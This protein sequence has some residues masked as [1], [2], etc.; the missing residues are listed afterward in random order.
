MACNTPDYRFQEQP[1][2][3]T[4]TTAFNEIQTAELTPN[5]QIQFAYGINANQIITRSN[6]SGTVSV[7]NGLSAIQT[8]AA[9]NSSCELLSRQVSKYRTGQGGLWRCAGFFTTG[10]AG[11][12]QLIGI[13]TDEDGFFFGYNG[14]DFGILSRRAGVVEIRTLTVATK[15][16]HG[17]NITI[18]L[19]GNAKTDVT[20]TNGADTTVTANEIAAAN[21]SSVGRGW[22][23][24]ANGSKVVFVSWG[25]GARSGTYSL[26]GATS[27]I[28]TFAQTRAGANSTDTWVAQ[29]D[30]NVDTFDGTGSSGVTLN[31]AKGNVYQIQYQWLGFGMIS[32][33]I[34]NP[35]TGK[36]VNVHN[37]QYANANT[38]L[39]VV[40]PTFPCYVAAINTTNTSNITVSTGSMMAGVQGIKEATGLNYGAS[41]TK[42]NAGATEIPILTIRNKV[43]FQNKLNRVTAKLTYMSASVEHTKA[44]TVNFY[45]NATLVGSSFAD[46]GTTT[47]VME[48]DTSA[49]S[50]SGGRKLFTLALGK[51]G[52]EVIQLLDTLAGLLNPGD[53]LTATSIPASQNN[54]ET[55]VS[56]NWTEDF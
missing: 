46:I 37:I 32:F 20:V 26:S 6:Q 9:A 18:T 17:E 11:S 21:Y 13:G 34:E 53:T 56:F 40:N 31:T 49:T 47:S 45:A 10:V 52:N 33:F 48:V 4:Q 19:N 41:A 14:A 27:A 22:S 51:T 55:T 43:V 36:M 29:T 15:S 42:T 3:I 2:N 16:S 23:A 25:A 30:W 44:V 1:V 38:V 39:S 12:E 28:G 50:F 5:V 24:Y 54:S 35:T 8:G 7:T